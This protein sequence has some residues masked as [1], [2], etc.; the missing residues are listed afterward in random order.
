MSLFFLS[1]LS[2]G[3]A[4]FFGPVQI[5]REGTRHIRKKGGE[6][7]RTYTRTYV[8]TPLQG[9]WGKG[10]SLKG[11]FALFPPPRSF[12]QQQ[13]QLVILGFS[14][15]ALTMG[16]RRRAGGKK[17]GDAIS[18]LFSLARKKKFFQ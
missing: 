16:E 6:C 11:L 12:I 14:M 7:E 1:P 3:A 10:T 2:L 18:S 9:A 4:P 8:R 17:K 13:Q 15:F 5:R